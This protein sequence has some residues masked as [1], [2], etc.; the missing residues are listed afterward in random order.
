MRNY[1]EFSWSQN[2]PEKRRVFDAAA[3]ASI[4]VPCA[5][6][7]GPMP[8]TVSGAD[9]AAAEGI[10]F[11]AFLASPVRPAGTLTAVHEV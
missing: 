4:A 10:H 7:A 2:Q 11:P 9:G 6:G 3:D 8:R 5:V 1:F